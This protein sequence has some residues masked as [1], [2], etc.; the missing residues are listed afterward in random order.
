V[1]AALTVTALGSC[2]T[3]WSAF[4]VLTLFQLL[5]PPCW[6]ELP[7][8]RPRVMTSLELPL[9]R[10][11]NVSRSVAKPLAW[12]CVVLASTP[13]AAVPAAEGLLS[14]KQRSDCAAGGITSVTTAAPASPLATAASTAV[15]AAA[16]AAAT[17]FT[18]ATA[19]AASFAAANAA[20]D[21]AAAAAGCRH[22]NPSCAKSFTTDATW[23]CFMLLR[24]LSS[25]C[26]MECASG[27]CHSTHAARAWLLQ[28]ELSC[29]TGQA[30]G[31]ASRL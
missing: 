29:N 1:T 13:A 16:A 12:S 17:S 30:S 4:A 7:S 27:G 2:C 8:P 21:A 31:K 26:S 11:R 23:Y 10:L 24:C 3:V 22:R 25:F 28:A 9:L 6:V 14:V 20:S 18:A 19:A 15:P 5:L